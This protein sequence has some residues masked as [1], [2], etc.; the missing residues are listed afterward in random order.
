[1]G[2]LNNNNKERSEI[3]V[4]I[5]AFE[6]LHNISVMKDN[7]L[8]T[9]QKNVGC[10]SVL[11]A[12][13]IGL[14]KD[15]CKIMQT[16]AL[17]HDIGKINIPNEILFK[18]TNLTHDEWAIMKQHP[19]MGAEIFHV[20]RHTD[21]PDFGKVV[22][23]I[24]HHHERWDGEGYPYGLK[25][26]NIPLESRIIAI[27]DAFDAMTTDRP[28]KKRMNLADACKEI[29]KCAG[30][31]FDPYLVERFIENIKDLNFPPG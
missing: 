11:M 4:A 23:I 15:A 31:Q 24:L 7:Y 25:G 2:Y 26:E 21:Y 6:L 19:I 5:H 8:A 17:F 16:S 12:E 1:L 13:F 30:K 28:Y 27:T 18:P 14:N 29:K 22:R 3:N 9:H 10:L 20:E